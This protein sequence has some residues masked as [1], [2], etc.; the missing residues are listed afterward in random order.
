MVHPRVY[1]SATQSEAEFL[2]D[3]EPSLATWADDDGLTLLMRALRNGDPASRVAIATRL[4]DD[5]ADAGA[6]TE[7]H[8][9]VLHL[10]LSATAHDFTA[11]AP[12]LARLIDEGADINADS[13]SRWGTPLQTLSRT[14]KFSDE[15][16]AP[17]YD[18]LFARPDL[19]VT[20]PSSVGRSV[21]ESAQ[22]AIR[23]RADLLARCHAHTKE[24]GSR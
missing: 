21:T 24:H 4:L 3:Y 23:R 14:L 15:T 1:F 13:G 19:D 9:N 8:V 12:L 20:T 6:S 5:G 10:L 17:F 22:A 18:V 11:E 16:L 2:D 7:S